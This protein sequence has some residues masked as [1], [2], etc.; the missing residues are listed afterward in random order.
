MVGLCSGKGLI[1]LMRQSQALQTKRNRYLTVL[2]VGELME[3]EF[4][5]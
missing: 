4:E 2:E 3:K 1:P 5:S